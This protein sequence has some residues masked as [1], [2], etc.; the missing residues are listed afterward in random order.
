MVFKSLVTKI[1]Q[2]KLIFKSKIEKAE[3]HEDVPRLVKV[4]NSH[5][6]NMFTI[7]TMEHP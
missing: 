6:I 3:I 5:V 1:I 7:P 2:V 4:T